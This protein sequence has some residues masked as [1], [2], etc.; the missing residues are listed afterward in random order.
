MMGIVIKDLGL[1]IVCQKLFDRKKGDTIEFNGHLE[2]L[3]V[4]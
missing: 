3:E 2:I 4:Q 1:I